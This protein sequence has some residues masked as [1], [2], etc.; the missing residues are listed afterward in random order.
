MPSA[1]AAVPGRSRV[2][3]G[4]GA[5]LAV[6]ALTACTRTVAGSASFASPEP[7][8]VV[9]QEPCEHS[10]FEC[11]TLAVPADHFAADSPTWEV[12]YAIHRGTEESRGVVVVATGGPGSSGID[13]SYDRLQ[14]MPAEITDSYDL[15]LFDQ[16]GVGL[17]EPFSCEE[18]V[19]DPAPAI[20]S[21][22][23]ALER[24]QFARVAEDFAAD[25]FDEAG[26][27][28]ADAGRYATRQAAEDL[29]HFREWLGVDRMVL[30]G[31]SYG[32]L[33]HQT[34]AAAHP[35]HV[36]ALVLDGVVDPTEDGITVGSEAARAFSDV[37]RATLDAC[38]AD[39]SC[40]RDAPG[41]ALEQYD[42]LAEKLT[43]KPT[44]FD[45][46]LPDGSTER[47]R[48][49]VD[50]L[51]SAAYWTLGE[52]SS[53]AALQQVL[54]AAA[55]GNLVPLARLVE[56]SWGAAPETDEAAPPDPEFS[57]SL[58]Y[59]VTCADYDGVPPGS[60]GRA[61]LDVWL[62]A[63]RS[64]D[65][66]GHRLGDVFYADL[67]CLFWPDTGAPTARPEPVTD[68]P[69]PLLLLTADTDPNTPTAAAHAVLQRTRDDVA[70]VSLQGGPHVIFGRGDACVDEP[71][72]TL[73]T[74]GRLPT[75]PVTVCSGEVAWSY[76]Q[77]PPVEED[78]YVT[79]RMTAYTTLD[80]V[81]NNP[82]YVVW[83]GTSPLD[84]GCD[85]GGSAHYE[86][87]QHDD[88]QVTLDEC[89]W[90]EGVP[91]NGTVTVEDDGYGA[92]SAALELPFGEL[93]LDADGDLSGE[94]R[95]R[96]V[97]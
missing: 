90:T 63:A 85:R 61:E 44:W 7:G 81:I 95:G 65:I 41:T 57:W 26:I 15:V 29:E 14:A 24:D 9:R 50:E 11:V 38:D 74:T 34:Y 13:A 28:P 91:V 40:A 59:A 53:R 33:L 12:T 10:E 96:T 1:S 36:E 68:P 25:C 86:V 67:P 22:A 42:R 54:N 69:Y 3:R 31:E 66:D 93:T 48:I 47:R 35:E 23:P 89:E 70:M 16:R 49:T 37:L 84:I 18:A 27:D 19:A 6:L 2:R 82:L 92:A 97:G 52:P 72:V 73:V 75:V 21:S 56:V 45:Y 46:P 88:V 79:P 87:D 5:L 55:V 39:R 30:Y 60:T 64:G 83:T 62:D 77:N 78:G 94:F 20:G 71:V 43:A 80:A 17:S 58:Y 76:L 32:T 4:T 8:E 51:R